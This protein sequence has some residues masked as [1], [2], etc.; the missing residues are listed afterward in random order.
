MIKEQFLVTVLCTNIHFT[1]ALEFTQMM[2][3]TPS[4]YN[5]SAQF[6]AR[7]RSFAFCSKEK[8]T[9]TMSNEHTGREK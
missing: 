6:F 8:T 2:K 1:D 3:G 7:T 9:I 4:I 5:T